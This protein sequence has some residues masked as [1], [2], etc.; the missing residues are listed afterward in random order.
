MRRSTH[1]PRDLVAYTAEP[2]DAYYLTEAPKT[3][4]IRASCEFD[5]LGYS[6]SSGRIEFAQEVDDL[7]SLSGEF[8]GLK[9]GLHAMKV[10]EFGDLE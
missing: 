8:T 4:T 1:R 5:F 9:P 7:V 3:E 2:V 6:E 10:H